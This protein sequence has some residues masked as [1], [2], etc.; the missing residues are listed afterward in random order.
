MRCPHEAKK[1]FG[2]CLEHG[3]Q[4]VNNRKSFL[5]Y[6]TRFQS[7]RRFDTLEALIKEGDV[8]AA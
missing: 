1:I 5:K 7:E 6:V 4:T 8:I 2:Q 3:Q